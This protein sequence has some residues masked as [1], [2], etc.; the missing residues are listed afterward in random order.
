MTQYITAVIKVAEKQPSKG[1]FHVARTDLV[2]IFKVGS[3]FNGGEVTAMSLEDE[4]TILEFIENHP[5]FD[6]SIGEEA[7]AK[8]VEM[9]KAAEGKNNV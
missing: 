8:T 2:D 4:M 3:C 1:N 9:H 5:D 6:Q 7:R